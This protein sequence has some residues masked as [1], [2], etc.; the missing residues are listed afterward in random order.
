MLIVLLDEP[1]LFVVPSAEAAAKEIESP[2]ART[3]LRS[4]LEGLRA[5]VDRR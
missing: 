2:E 5:R 1:G 4:L 3:A